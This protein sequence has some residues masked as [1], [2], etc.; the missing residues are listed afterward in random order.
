[1]QEDENR[2]KIGNT[3]SGTLGIGREEELDWRGNPIPKQQA[4]EKK[5]DS[6]GQNG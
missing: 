3:S 2:N 4:E 6:D 1:M 5:E